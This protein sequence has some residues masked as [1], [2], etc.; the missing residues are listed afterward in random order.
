MKENVK[1][2][3]LIA[4]DY[5]V[6]A[7][8]TT[9]VLLLAISIY[10]FLA[11]VNENMTLTYVFGGI[12]II[13]MIFSCIRL[14][15]LNHLVQIGAPSKGKVTAIYFYRSRGSVS[16]E[17]HFEGSMV[18]TR[19]SVVRNAKSR[20]IQPQQEINLLINPKKPVQALILDLYR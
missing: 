5:L 16:F 6:F 19:C 4:N 3:K 17:Y 11:T 18:K 1:L 9:G 2:S 15:I 7:G 14:I 20:A 10:G 8:F 13:S 12:A